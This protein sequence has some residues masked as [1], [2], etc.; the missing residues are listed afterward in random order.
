MTCVITKHSQKALS[1]IGRAQLILHYTNFTVSCTHKSFSVTTFFRNA[2][3][4]RT[5]KT[6]IFNLQYIQSDFNLSNAL[7]LLNELILSLRQ[8]YENNDDI[9]FIMTKAL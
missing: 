5:I 8:S 7:L 2:A 1:N 6:N 3:C 4:K 9:D